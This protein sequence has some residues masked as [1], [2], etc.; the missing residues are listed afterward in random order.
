MARVWV[1]PT[2]L[3]ILNVQ[4]INEDYDT[5]NMLNALYTCTVSGVLRVLD[6]HRAGLLETQNGSGV[7]ARRPA[8][9]RAA[10]PHRPAHPL[11]IALRRHAGGDRLGDLSEGVHVP[12]KRTTNKLPCPPRPRRPAPNPDTR[13][14][15]KRPTGPG[16]ERSA[17]C[18][19]RR[20]R[21]VRRSRRG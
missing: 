11:L 18:A 7:C 9:G 10:V 16:T 21:R 14:N 19:A 20:A 6:S 1:I 12:T 8:H 15:P 3:H 13:P 4:H 2:P 5:H 17:H